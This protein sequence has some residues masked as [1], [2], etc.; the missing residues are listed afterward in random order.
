MHGMH[1]IYMHIHACIMSL[2]SDAGKAESLCVKVI[3]C[4]ISY[5]DQMKDS[6]TLYSDSEQALNCLLNPDTC[7]CVLG[8]VPIVKIT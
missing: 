2:V 8:I 3:Y 5:T 7:K 6:M 1:A 4:N